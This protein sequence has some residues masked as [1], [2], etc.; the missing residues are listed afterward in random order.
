MPKSWS[1]LKIGVPTFR[2]ADKF[3]KACGLI[4]VK[5]I[6]ANIDAG[7]RPDGTMQKQNDPDYAHRK[8][9]VMG[10]HTPVKGIK[11]HG[12]DHSPYIARHSYIAW[13]R[14]FFPPAK[15][16]IHL[17]PIRAEIGKKLTRAG[18]WFVGVTQ[19]AERQIAQRTYQY[20]QTK[21]RQMRSGR[22]V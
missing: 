3:L 1:Q 19:E 17:K 22:E 13:A 10:Y 15:L 2:D 18:Y 11:S 7:V 16:L 5:R 12:R 4:V 21:L 8:A 14:D 6:V 9:V 20:L